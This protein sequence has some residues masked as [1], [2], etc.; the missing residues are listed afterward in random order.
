MNAERHTFDTYSETMSTF[1]M[2][3]NQVVLGYKIKKS[4]K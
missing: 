1:F 4:N 3:T 2:H